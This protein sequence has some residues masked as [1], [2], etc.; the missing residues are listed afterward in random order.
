MYMHDQKIQLSW[1]ARCIVAALVIMV[2][3]F[4][5]MSQESAGP[6]IAG[7]VLDEQGG[8]ILGARATLTD[9]SGHETA[10]ATNGAGKFVFSN[11]AQG[12]YTLR[13]TADHFR[14]YENA[15]IQVASANNEINLNVTMQIAG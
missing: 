3:S 6:S 10:Q 5:A 15:R 2:C 12:T 9:T 1:I 8:V 13:V 7:Q 4:R 14:P 11:V